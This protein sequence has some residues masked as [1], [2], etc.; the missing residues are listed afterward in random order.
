MLFDFDVI[1]ISRWK[2]TDGYQV[3]AEP[4]IDH[5]VVTPEPAREPTPKSFFVTDPQS[6]QKPLLFNLSNISPP[7]MAARHNSLQ[8]QLSSAF[9]MIDP[10]NLAYGT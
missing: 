1:P 6:M 2:P 10:P 8:S 7:L 9:K 4:I 5:D 3:I